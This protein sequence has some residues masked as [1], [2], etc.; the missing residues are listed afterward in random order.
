[1]TFGAVRISIQQPAKLNQFAACY[2]CRHDKQ[3][4]NSLVLR[5]T[6]ALSNHWSFKLARYCGR[7]VRNFSVPSPRVLSAAFVGVVLLV[8]S[9]YYFVARVFFCEPFFKGYCTKYGKNLHTGVYLHWIQGQGEL[10]VGD[11]VTLDGKCSISFAVRYSDRPTLII[12]DHTI[13]GHGTSFTVGDRITVGRHCQI[14]GGVAILDAPGHPLDPVAR[15]EGKPAMREDVRP[16]VIEDDVW[17]G[18]RS[19]ILPGVTIGRGSVVAAG[20][21]VMTSVPPNVLVAGNPARQFRALVQTPPAASTTPS[22]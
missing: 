2:N 11:N 21:V 20:S 22:T 3:G 7:A 10:V 13:I 16:V 19:I 8:R 6:I 18:Q 4:E 15:R 5:R 12:G 14:A 1:M 17:I 9:V